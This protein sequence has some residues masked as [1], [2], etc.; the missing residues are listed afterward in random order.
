MRVHPVLAVTME[1]KLD[2]EL[3]S[4][5]RAMRGQHARLLATQIGQD[6]SSRSEVLHS[7]S[8][9]TQQLAAL[10]MSLSWRITAPLRW[11]GQLFISPAAAFASL[12]HTKP[13]DRLIRWGLEQPRLIALVHRIL[14]R[15]PALR[16]RIT[17]RVLRSMDGS[18]NSQNASDS[19]M[20]LS[21]RRIC[22][23]L[24]QRAATSGDEMRSKG[25][26]ATP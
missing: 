22:N 25:R 17:R 7:R 4:A 11:V 23:R 15:F 16:D 26:Q 20:P 13:V 18:T 8:S 3:L 2:L 5:L 14:R 1:P 12:L 6:C 10:K 19:D 9:D 24:A 21:A